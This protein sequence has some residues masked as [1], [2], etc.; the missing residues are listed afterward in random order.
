MPVRKP[1]G[2]ELTEGNRVKCGNGWRCKTCMDQENAEIFAG[3]ARCDWVRVRYLLAGKLPKDGVEPTHMEILVASE[4]LRSR[5]E[6]GDG[7]A[8]ARIGVTASRWDVA[9]SWMH[10]HKVRIPTLREVEWADYQVSA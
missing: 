8:W 10:K 2:H 1:C 5:S 6:R 4:H 3:H 7:P 9:R